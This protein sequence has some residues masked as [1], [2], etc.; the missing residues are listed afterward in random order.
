MYSQ[1][2]KFFTNQT[3]PVDTNLKVKKIIFTYT[4]I[5]NKLNPTLKNKILY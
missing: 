3:N 2:T 4:N 5:F 1:C